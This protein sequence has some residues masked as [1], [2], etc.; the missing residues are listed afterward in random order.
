VEAAEGFKVRTVA[1]TGLLLAEDAG[2][3]DGAALLT[4]A[5]ATDGTPLGLEEVP[6]TKVGQTAICCPGPHGVHCE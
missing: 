5:G 2:I 6:A 3:Q 1:K 4:A